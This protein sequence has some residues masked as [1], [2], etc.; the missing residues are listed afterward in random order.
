MKN[1]DIAQTVFHHLG[2]ADLS[3]LRSTSRSVRQA[4][5][6][7]CKTF[8][9]PVQCGLTASVDPLTLKWHEKRDRVRLCLSSAP[10]GLPGWHINQYNNNGKFFYEISYLGEIK[11]YGLSSCWPI[12]RPSNNGMVLV[13]FSDPDGG[14]V[15]I[16]I[17]PQL[18]WIDYYAYHQNIVAPDAV[19]HYDGV[20][21]LSQMQTFR[22][23]IYGGQ[24][25]LDPCETLKLVRFSLWIPELKTLLLVPRGGLAWLVLE[26]NRK[27]HL[28][29]PFT[30]SRE[31]LTQASWS[32]NKGFLYVVGGKKPS[33]HRSN[34]IWKADLANYVKL[35]LEC[36]DLVVATFQYLSALRTFLH[37]HDPNLFDRPLLHL[38]RPTNPL[39]L[40]WIKHYKRGLCPPQ[41][42]DPVWKVAES[43]PRSITTAAVRF[44]DHGRVMMIAGGL[45]SRNCR[46]S[47]VEFFAVDDKGSLKCL[48]PMPQ[49]FSPD[50]TMH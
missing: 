32:Y 17:G 16:D 47:S 25:D 14:I 9:P 41:I 26:N 40:K 43:L 6:V 5:S 31:N 24:C 4:V 44:L 13:T 28:E 22:G 37:E 15:T 42:I 21:N 23:F 18:F 3:T 2:L 12:V 36:P 48:D 33:G 39:A 10:T 35:S 45:A 50:S 29:I 1:R 30:L 20:N 8:H 49:S 38:W 7:Y 19:L 11:W 34:L 27:V 46:T